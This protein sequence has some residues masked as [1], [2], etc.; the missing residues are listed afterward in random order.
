MN[1]AEISKA[2]A[3]QRAYA[4][5]WRAKNR[6]KIRAANQRYWLRKAEQLESKEGEAAKNEQ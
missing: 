5:A 2:K 3:A 6:D 1:E 4:K